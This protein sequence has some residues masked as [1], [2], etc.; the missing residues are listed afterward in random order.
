LAY[1]VAKEQES[2][3]F[4]PS[5][6][7]AA[8]PTVAELTAGDDIT[9]DI[10]SVT[11]FTAETNFV[12]VPT[13]KGGRAPKLA[14]GQTTA[15]SSLTMAEHSTYVSNGTKQ[16]LAEG[17]DGFIVISRYKKAP[18]AAAD[19]VDVLPVTIGGNNRT[20]TVDDAPGEYTVS[21]GITADA[22]IDATVAA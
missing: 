8:A 10:R 18:L 20:H 22:E 17:T 9:D 5:I 12:D 6:A 2:W 1:F 4:V 21:F 16:A 11:G 19:K 15:D 3:L 14:G 7:S 13:M